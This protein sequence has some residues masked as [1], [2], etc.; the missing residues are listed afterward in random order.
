M[1]HPVTVVIDPLEAHLLKAETFRVGLVVP[2]SGV[3]GLAGPCAINCAMLAA[4]EVNASGGV[5]GK[6]IELVLID[7][8]AAPAEV[9]REVAGL[10][11]AGAVQGL[12]GTHTSDVRVA[13]E[14]SV[15]GAVPFV[16]TP[17]YE[18]G[19]RRPGVY[20]L[21]EPA[22]RQVGPGLD[23]LI[24]NRRARRWFLLGNDYVWPHLV[25]ASARA[26]LRARSATVIG[27][28]FVPFGAIDTGRIIEQL[29]AVRPDAVLVNL[30]GSDL[31]AFNRAFT[32]SGLGCARLCGALEEHGLLAIGGDTTGE[33]YAAMGYFG[34]LATEANL[35]L[36][37]RYTRGFGPAAP[38]LNGH[39]HGCYEGVA[40]LAALA[41]RAGSPSVRAIETTADGTTITGGRGRLTLEDRQVNQRVYVGR[42]DGLDFDVVTSV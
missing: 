38:L 6:A 33:L 9:A 40:M 34:S 20:F 22:S 13:I 1:T 10:A 27:E 18:G 7:A 2:V 30:I 36:A 26:H 14:R 35:G 4:S 23:W 37:E 21:G 25:H 28:R 16:Y 19:A 5:L 32:A 8:G 41:R 15:A 29:A 31:V 11:S 17:P 3:L 12:V 42:A 24:D 39:G